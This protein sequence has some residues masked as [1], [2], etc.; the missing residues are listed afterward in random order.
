MIRKIIIRNFSILLYI[1]F[2]IS[3]AEVHGQIKNIGT[4]NIINYPNSIYEAGTQNWG[5]SQDEN[6]FMYFAN[7]YNKV[8]IFFNFGSMGNDE[9]YYWDDVKFGPLTSINESE[10]QQL[11][12][13]Q[14]PV[15]D[16][17]VLDDINNIESVF[18]YNLA[19]Q[20]CK[21]EKIN[22]GSYNVSELN[23]GVYTVLVID[24]MG[25]NFVGKMLKK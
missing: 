13:L 6:G 17:L 14:N 22:Q 21:I 12:I 8:S 20:V 5:I 1:L 9:T 11:S 2:L 24:E 19:G 10:I 3:S 25:N 7:N 18:V 15:R 4:P 23:N 16:I